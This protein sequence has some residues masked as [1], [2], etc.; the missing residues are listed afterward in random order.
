MIESIKG[1]MNWFAAVVALCACAALFAFG[2]LALHRLPVA[3]DSVYRLRAERY[4]PCSACGQQC[5]PEVVH[6]RGWR[7]C[8]ACASA[9][10]ADGVSEVNVR[11]WAHGRLSKIPYPVALPPYHEEGAP[12]QICLRCGGAVEENIPCENADCPLPQPQAPVIV[13]E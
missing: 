12:P 10:S 2:G 5:G 3:T 8:P 1:W 11:R 9:A 4:A 6:G 7:L 13:I